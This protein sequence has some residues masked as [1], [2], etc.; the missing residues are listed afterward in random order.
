MNA[1]RAARHR[2]R[3]LASISLLTAFPL[4]A[5]A[6]STIEGI[7]AAS[8]KVFNGY[9]RVRLPDGSFK[10]ETYAFGNGGF[11][12]AGSAGAETPG[13]QR[14]TTI[15]NLGFDSIAKA[16]NEPLSGQ[17][18]VPSTDP[19]AT[20]L[21]VMVFWGTTVGGYHEKKGKFRDLLDLKNAAL[22]GFD[23][24]ALFGQGFGNNVRSNIQKQVHSQMLDALE[25]NRYFVILRAFDFQASL[26]Q[27]KI[28]LLWETR[29]SINQ[30][31]N[32][33]DEALPLMAQYA[34]QCFGQDSRGLMMARVSEGR[35][36]LGDITSLGEVN[37][38]QK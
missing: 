1:T 21:L 13:A 10:P 4:G 25:S 9:A 6:A 12:T 7:T 33:F 3:I 27:K 24:E 19:D 37:P 14:D 26:K 29:F 22:L 35:V 11:V 5:V 38:P 28:R 16:M 15:D 20:N 36:L 18:Y 8:S 32:A 31:R 17:N 30:R 23:S 34:S 2:S